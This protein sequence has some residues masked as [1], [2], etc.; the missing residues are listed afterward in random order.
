MNERQ[1]RILNLCN[2][3]TFI[4]LSELS[5]LF[6]NTSQ[7]T[8]RRDIESLAANGLVVKI[9]G[10]ARRVNGLYQE[11]AF[12]KR[13]AENHDLKTLIAAAAT[14]YVKQG[15]LIFL[16]SGSTT[17]NLARMIHDMPLSIYTTGT[18]IASILCQKQQLNVYLTGGKLSGKNLS[19]S[20]SEAMASLEH[21]NFDTVFMVASGYAPGSEFSCGNPEEA[22]LKRYIIS[23]AARVVMLIDETKVS[24]SLHHTFCTPCEVDVIVTT[25]PF[26]TEYK[27]HIKSQNKN[28]VFNIKTK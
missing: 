10:G 3:N 5:N 23:K 13:V 6:P 15:G 14:E 8:L 17:D 24:K 28:I 26:P 12:A 22:A 18:N 4:Y 25:K 27:K 1:E 21:V 11:D 9:R 2:T 20:G 16:D 19:L 7:M